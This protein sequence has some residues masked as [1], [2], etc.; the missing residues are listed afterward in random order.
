MSAL[1]PES[2]HHDLLMLFRSVA[3][4]LALSIHAA[5]LVFANEVVSI[6]VM[7]K[8]LSFELALFRRAPRQS[9]GVSPKSLKALLHSVGETG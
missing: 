4:A 2:G 8:W 6:F 5:A 7:S 3:T 1:R 9:P